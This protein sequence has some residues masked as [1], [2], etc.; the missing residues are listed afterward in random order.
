MNAED[1]VELDTA[2][3]LGSIVVPNAE[4]KVE[5]NLSVPPTLAL[6]LALLVVG[7]G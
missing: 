7:E 5:A 2:S 4:A 1:S 3:V 6:A